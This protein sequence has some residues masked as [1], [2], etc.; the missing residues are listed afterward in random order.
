[1]AFDGFEKQFID[2][3][4][5]VDLLPVEIL[6]NVAA[7]SKTRGLCSYFGLLVCVHD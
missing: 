7:N 5:L 1:M 6:K 2:E 3:F 4:A